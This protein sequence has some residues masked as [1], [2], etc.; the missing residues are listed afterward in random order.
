MFYNNNNQE[1]PLFNH[2]YDKPKDADNKKPIFCFD[3]ITEYMA[4]NK[5]YSLRCD[6]K[7]KQKASE[8]LDKITILSQKTWSEISAESKETG[9]ETIPLKNMSGVDKY[10][11]LFSKDFK[12]MVFRLKRS[13][14]TT[15]FMGI[16]DPRNPQVFQICIFDKF[17]KAYN[18]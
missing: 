7:C 6:K 9:Y 18:H 17:G 10:V 16:R 15:R 8:L 11:Q 12:F 1:E 3:Y 5:N 2:E 13:K 14:D 4:S